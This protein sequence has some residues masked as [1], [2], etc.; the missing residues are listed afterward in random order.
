[1]GCTRLD[2]NRAV[3]FLHQTNLA[4][5]PAASRALSE[6]CVDPLRPPCL[7]GL[8]TT[9]NDAWNH[10]SA[11]YLER[12]TSEP[13]VAQ[14][15]GSFRA[16]SGPGLCGKISTTTL[17]S[18]PA[19]LALVFRPT[20]DGR[21][22]AVNLHLLLNTTSLKT[23]LHRGSGPFRVGLAQPSLP[24]GLRHGQSKVERFSEIL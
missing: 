16:R 10:S 12:F 23:F 5:E 14:P 24:G 1:M 21:L 17:P 6:C 3:F 15:D 7:S 11:R 8:G 2:L 20:F 19:P 22:S 9:M 4:F 18:F 13:C